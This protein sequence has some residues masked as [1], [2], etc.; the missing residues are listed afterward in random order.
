ML[1]SSLFI[2]S[3]VLL[4]ACTQPPAVVELRG[5]HDYSRDGNFTQQV[6]S[7]PVAPVS[8]VGAQPVYN[9]QRAK[10]NLVWT[11][12]TPSQT[13]AS[14]GSIAVN[15]L[16]P[17]AGGE[18]AQPAPAAA[19][20]PVTLVNTEGAAPV[21]A[22]TNKPRDT[23][24]ATSKSAF[25]WPVAS[26]D[27]ISSFG[28]KG[29]GKANDGVNIA[30]SEGEPVWA[31]AD[32]EVVYAD[33]KMKGYGNMVLVKHKSGRT[34]TYAHLAR[35]GVDKYDRVKQGDIIGYVGATGNVKKSQLYFSMRDGTK[36]VDPQKMIDRNLAGL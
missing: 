20:E 8:Y 27:I 22:W 32:G 19:P 26:N 30:A 36:A 14:S 10:E 34:T 28:N 4:A 13:A 17:A 35:L 5:A 7:A 31:A 23:A 24:A 6:A 15:D 16:S 1:R 9:E 2:S 11:T 29:A 25:I 12:G 18:S 21:N 33:N 3:C